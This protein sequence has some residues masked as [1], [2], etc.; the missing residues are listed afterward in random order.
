LR[1][2]QPQTAFTGDHFQGMLALVQ[3]AAQGESVAW[4]YMAI[5]FLTGFGSDALRAQVPSAALDDG[6]TPFAV[7]AELTQ[8]RAAGTEPC[9]AMGIA[10]L[11]VAA[12]KGNLAAA[13]ALAWRYKRGVCV[14]ACHETA[15][16]YARWAGESAADRYHRRGAQPLLQRDRIDHSTGREV[17]RRSWCSVGGMSTANA[18]WLAVRSCTKANEDF[19]ITSSKLRLHSQNR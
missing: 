17:R 8:L 6:R 1:A 13:A 18:R 15:A 11:H 12:V 9:P 2:R 5:V 16:W 4:F 19:P 3:A 7:P 10:L 14:P